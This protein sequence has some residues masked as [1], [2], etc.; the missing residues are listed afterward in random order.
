M[1]TWGHWYWPIFLITSAL[2]I[3]TAFGIPELIAIF[4]QVSTHTDNTL[5]AYA[6]RELGVSAQLTVHTIAWYLSLITW[7]FLTTLLTW[8]IWFGFGG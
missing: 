4:T 2:F 8:H 5:S 7:V 1:I 6:Q 3:L